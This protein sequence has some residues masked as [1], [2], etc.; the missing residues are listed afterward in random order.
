MPLIC[1]VTL[2]MRYTFFTNACK[3][4]V[5]A[6]VHTQ[7]FQQDFPPELS[8]QTT[9]NETAK[10]CCQAFS[11]VKLNTVKTSIVVTPITG[12][13][14]AEE[15]GKLASAADEEKFLYQIQVR[16]SGQLYPIVDLPQGV[17]GIS[18]PGLTMPYAVDT[19]AREVSENT[20]GLNK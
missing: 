14:S 11:G 3:Q 5:H 17:L 6:A 12:G 10:K 16:M 15:P 8:A 2:G 19:F 1:L 20:Q 9:A 18:I 7:S 13:A 4:A